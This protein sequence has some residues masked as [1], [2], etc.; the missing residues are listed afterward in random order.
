MFN[1]YE[2]S[3]FTKTAP[4]LFIDILFL[5]IHSHTYL[6]SCKLISLQYDLIDD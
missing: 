4:D 3:L 5:V 1:Y 2:I 6:I